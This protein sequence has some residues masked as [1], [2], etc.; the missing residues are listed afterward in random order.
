MIPIR[1]LMPLI[2]IWF[3]DKRQLQKAY[4]RSCYM[5]RTMICPLFNGLLALCYFEP[6]ESHAQVMLKL[7][8][9]TFKRFLLI[10]K[11]TNTKLVNEVIG[12][13]IKQLID[14]NAQNF[15]CKWYARFERIQPVLIERDR[16]NDY[17]IGI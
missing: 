5:W 13:D 15:A 9:S 11:N 3:N 4:K 16:L 14:L 10:P 6:S 7:W 17:L 1:F 8:H 12:V 2:R